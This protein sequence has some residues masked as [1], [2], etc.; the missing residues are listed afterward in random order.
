MASSSF[1]HIGRY[2]VLTKLG[3]GGM[4]V[5]YKVHDTV[6]D[7]AVALKI[8]PPELVEDHDRVRRFVQEAKSASALNH[9]HIVTIYEIGQAMIEAP[10]ESAAEESAQSSSGNLA[11]EIL[12]LKSST[13]EVHYIAME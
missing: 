7:R 12:K 10:P 1:T 11:F 9:P 3:V 4:G 6:L 13:R 8:L 5:V 2:E